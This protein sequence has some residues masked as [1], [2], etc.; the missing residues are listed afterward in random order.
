MGVILLVYVV[1]RDS[2]GISRTGVIRPACVAGGVACGK[3]NGWSWGSVPCMLWHAQLAEAVPEAGRV[4]SL[5]RMNLHDDVLPGEPTDF[6]VCACFPIFGVGVYGNPTPWR[7]IS[8]WKRWNPAVPENAP[9]AGSGRMPLDSSNRRKLPRNPGSSP[10]D[11]RF[12][13]DLPRQPWES[14]QIRAVMAESPYPAARTAGGALTS[15]LSGLPR[16]RLRSERPDGQGIPRCASTAYAP[17]LDPG[18][19]GQPSVPCR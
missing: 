12:A 1:S 3:R 2:R 7:L 17:R 5:W 9:E 4:G 10:A 15:G 11:G 18:S 19:C 13:R 14:T 6:L 16:A 8:Q